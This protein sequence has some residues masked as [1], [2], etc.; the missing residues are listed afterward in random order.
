MLR[1]KITNKDTFQ[2]REEEVLSPLPTKGRSS[3][4][5]RLARKADDNLAHKQSRSGVFGSQGTFGGGTANN[6]ISHHGDVKQ[7]DP[8]QGS[9]HH[10]VQELFPPIL[11]KHQIGSHDPVLDE[12][13]AK[14]KSGLQLG[15]NTQ[16]Q[17]TTTFSNMTAS[18]KPVIHNIPSPRFPIKQEAVSTTRMPQ[19]TCPPAES[20]ICFRPLK[21]V[22][23]EVCAETFCA[24]VALVCIIHPRALYLQDVK[25]CR[26]CEQTNKQA[27]KEYDLP[28][29]MEKGIRNVVDRKSR[30][31]GM[32]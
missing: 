19:K 14:L 6:G 11:A 30:G 16:M 28:P 3:F 20:C 1:K 32:K 4:Q 5:S 18:Q 13:V 2:F 12:I 7:E 21:L 29:G 26:G 22:M 8:R 24:R 23:C 15:S 27:L 10:H 25:E 9:H 17:A 31:V